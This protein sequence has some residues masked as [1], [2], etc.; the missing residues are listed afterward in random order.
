METFVKD[1]I[2]NVQSLLNGSSAESAA[3]A[4]IYFLCRRGNDSLVSALA[5][6]KALQEVDPENSR[7]WQINDVIG[8]VRAWSKEVDPFF[9]VY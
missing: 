1:P 8:G 3:G 5:L 6:R 4:N 9:P 7:N 2:K